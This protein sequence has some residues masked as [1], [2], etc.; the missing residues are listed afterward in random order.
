MITVKN[1]SPFWIR[2]FG[3]GTR[4][5]DRE[6]CVCVCVCVCVCFALANRTYLVIFLKK[7]IL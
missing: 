5:V 4:G 2:D 1:P 3:L 6:E 7:I